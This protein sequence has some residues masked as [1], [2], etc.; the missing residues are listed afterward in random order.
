MTARLPDPEFDIAVVGAGM[1]GITCAQQLS[2]AG[3]RVVVLEKSRGVGGRMATRRLQGTCADHGTCYLSPQ[4]DRFQTLID[5]LAAAGILQSWTDR[6]YELDVNAVSLQAPTAAECYPRYVAPTGM[7]AIVK[8]LAAGLDIRFNQRV[9]KLELIDE[10]HWRL[11]AE[12]TG[13]EPG[14]AE[15]TE[16]SATAVVVA[17]PAPQASLLLQPLMELLPA[18]FIQQLQSAT[19]L[20]CLS[21]MVGYLPER[22]QDWLSDYADLK[23]ISVTNDTMLAWIGLDSSKRAQSAQPVF[24]MQSTV[25]FADRYLEVSDLSAAGAQLI[26]RAAELLAPWLDTPEWLQ[27]HRWRYAFAQ[28]P[29]PHPYLAALTPAALICIGDWCGG[30]KVESAYLSGL[31]AATYWLSN[32]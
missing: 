16:L 12:S 19:F 11:T 3:Y 2:Q 24:V 31:D 10:Q 22:Q 28:A 8:H 9:A 13:A 15:Q 4:G 5:Q 21:A 26:Q 17:I 27:V 1:A 25:E 23:A 18:E 6:V 29:L 14:T 20:P 7:T 32:N 30:R